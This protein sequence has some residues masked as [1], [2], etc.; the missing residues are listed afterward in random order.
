VRYPFLTKKHLFVIQTV[1]NKKYWLRL[2]KELSIK[3]LNSTKRTD[4]NTVIGE[5]SGRGFARDM[6]RKMRDR[7]E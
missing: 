2:K 3:K 7:D 4:A 1:L 5:I 6:T